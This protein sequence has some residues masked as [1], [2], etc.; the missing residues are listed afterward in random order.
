MKNCSGEVTWWDKF[1]APVIIHRGCKAT[2]L[3]AMRI[4]SWNTCEFR[5]AQSV[6]KF[7]EMLS[8][9]DPEVVFLQETNV[10]A[11]YFD[12]CKF[13]FGFTHYLAID[14]V[15][16]GR[17]L[18]LL[19]KKKRLSL[20]SYN[21]LVPLYMEKFLRR[22]TET[23]SGGFWVFMGTLKLR[24]KPRPRILLNCFVETQI[25]GPWVNEILNQN[26]KWDGS[27]RPE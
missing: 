15:E 5:N 13:S 9:K 6:R 21:I 20:K 2:P 17:S 24:G 16:L 14:W 12:A 7:Q 8:K 11:S 27:T 23:S 19:W 4:L 26:K 22:L 25:G 18:P 3:S 1:R 10:H